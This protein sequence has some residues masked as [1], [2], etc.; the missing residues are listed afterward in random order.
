MGYEQRK[1][2][3]TCM[4]YPF[5]KKLELATKSTGGGAMENNDE[6]QRSSVFP[7]SPGDTPPLWANGAF[8][9][10]AD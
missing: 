7:F 1:K 6:Y 5:S 4:A 2:F 10:N 3:L 8:Y 9:P